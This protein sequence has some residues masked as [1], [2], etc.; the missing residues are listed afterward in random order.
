MI[1]YK[2]KLEER[3]VNSTK[4][5]KEEESK[6]GYSKDINNDNIDKAIKALSAVI[7]PDEFRTRLITFLESLKEYIYLI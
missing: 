5:L 2:V 3:E 7:V 4:Q 1:S 6:L